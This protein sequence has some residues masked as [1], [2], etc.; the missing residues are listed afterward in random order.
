M[1]D[2]S[3]LLSNL[4]DY[5]AALDRHYAALQERHDVLHAAWASL[6]EIYDGEAAKD[7]AEA[8]ERANERFRAYLE[9]GEAIQ[10]TLNR[11]IE[12]LRQFDSGHTPGL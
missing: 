1:V 7:F 9:Q 8:Y 4:E 3:L 12:E 2:T 11:K 10:A 6:A 5:K